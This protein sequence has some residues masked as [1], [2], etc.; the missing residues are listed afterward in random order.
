MDYAE[1][2]KDELPPSLFA[3]L[4]LRQYRLD[5]SVGITRIRPVVE[6]LLINWMQAKQRERAIKEAGAMSG[7]VMA[8]NEHIREIIAELERG[9]SP[10]RFEE[11]RAEVYG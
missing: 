8:E 11:L 2:A 5:Q 1:P 6:V 3:A 7:E 9:V 10:E 4:A